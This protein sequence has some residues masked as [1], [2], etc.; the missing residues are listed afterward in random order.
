MIPHRRLPHW[1][2]IA[3]LTACIG[4][5]SCTPARAVA[6]PM[7]SPNAQSAP[8]ILPADLDVVIWLDVARLRG[9]WT[10][11]PN[12]QLATILGEYGL[13]AADPEE[14]DEVGFWLR[15]VSQTDKLW[16]ACRPVPSGCTDFVVFA[17]GRYE[18]PDPVQSLPD[19][20]HP[21]DLGAGW[22][23]YDRRRPTARRGSSRIYVAPPD[24]I[25]V[26]SL[27][28]LDAV[29]RSLEEGS[30][31][32][33]LH[34]EERGL[35]SLSFRPV[36][37]A[38]ALET[39]AP[40]AARFLREANGVRLWLDSGVEVMTL[41]VVIGFGTPERAE[42]ARQAFALLSSGLDWL[43]GKTNSTKGPADAFSVKVVGNDLLLNLR[44][45]PPNS[46]PSHGSNGNEPAKQ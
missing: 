39:R 3:S 9:L 37:V 40:A 38:R 6:P 31:D 12:V 45:Q 15:L 28:E 35:F 46:A 41:S 42:R 16:I 23:R 4:P 14:A 26:V 11:K 43:H 29:E 27:T 32:D 8:E 13:Y 18:Q 19:L 5:M 36:G 34:V 25:V 21:V 30:L 7:R 1:I 20:R 24:R 22:F 2:A 33:S 44:V 10:V 17:R